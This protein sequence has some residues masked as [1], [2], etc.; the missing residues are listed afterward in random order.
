MLATVVSAALRGIESYLI[1]VEG[2]GHG[3][4]APEVGER[5]KLFLEKHLRNEKVEIPD[6][7]VE[8]EPRR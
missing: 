7:P 1:R 3:F 8:V 6:E 4:A 5:V 2:A